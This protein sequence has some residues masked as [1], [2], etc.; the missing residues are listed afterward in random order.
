MDLPKVPE[1]T[2]CKDACLCNLLFLELVK[3]MEK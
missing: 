2:D 1:T 3:N